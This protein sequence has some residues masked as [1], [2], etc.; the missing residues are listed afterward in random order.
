MDVSQ[1]LVDLAGRATVGFIGIRSD[2]SVLRGSGTLIKFGQLAGILTCHHVLAGSLAEGQVGLLCFPPN[3]QRTQTAKFS[4]DQDQTI[5]CGPGP[6]ERSGPDLAFAAIPPDVMGYLE[7]KATFINASVHRDRARQVAQTGAKSVSAIAGAVD[8]LSDPEPKVSGAVV[9]NLF[10][11]RIYP[12]N[13]M[14]TYTSDDMDYFRFQPKFADEEKPPSSYRGMSGGGLWKAY[15]DQNNSETVRLAGVS[16]YQTPDDG[17]R[18]IIGHGDR[19]I[20]EMFYEKIMAKWPKAEL[21]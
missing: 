2:H 20:F 21:S 18:H 15:L 16:Y 3:S 13:I 10:D 8:E 14:E 9:T 17:E 12:G 11:A 6:N 5:S 1:P 19:S 4:I 7:A